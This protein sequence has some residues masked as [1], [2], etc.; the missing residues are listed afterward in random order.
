MTIEKVKGVISEEAV[1]YLNVA[2]FVFC[3]L[4]FIL[5]VFFGI[6]VIFEDVNLLGFVS[7]IRAK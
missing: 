6:F 5:I 4:F 1:A 2:F 7:F 3:F